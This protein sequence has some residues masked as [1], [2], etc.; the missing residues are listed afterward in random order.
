MKIKVV[1]R[2]ESVVLFQKE[3]DEVKEV[4]LFRESFQG[5]IRETF[6]LEVVVNPQEGESEDYWRGY[7]D[8]EEYYRKGGSFK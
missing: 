4:D 3:Y 8:A 7:N 5:N 6:Q 2:R 1:L